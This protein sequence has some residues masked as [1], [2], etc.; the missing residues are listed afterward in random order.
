M[1]FPSVVQSQF[2]WVN[3]GGQDSI[4]RG[5]PSAP[6]LTL[7]YAISQITDASTA[8]QYFIFIGPGVYS[9]PTGLKPNIHLIGGVAGISHNTY[10]GV[11][12]SGVMT[13]LGSAAHGDGNGFTGLSFT[14]EIRLHDTLGAYIARYHFANCHFSNRILSKSTNFSARY[15]G[16]IFGD[17]SLLGLTAEYSGCLFG[18]LFRVAVAGGGYATAT[19]AT[20]TGSRIAGDVTL[21]ANTTAFFRGVGN[22]YGGAINLDGTGCTVEIDAAAPEPSIISGSP[23]VT[24][25]N[26]ALRLKYAPG[27]PADWNATPPANVSAAL[28]RLAAVA[29][30]PP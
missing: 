12:I 3:K 19:S 5:V 29:S 23:T 13:V 10:E 27:T 22:S 4:G 11:E 15:S 2:L 6:L 25:I 1:N 16:C 7:D 24:L 14:D 8:K 18:G 28:D 30:T 20:V 17:Y 9:S 21:L 26:N